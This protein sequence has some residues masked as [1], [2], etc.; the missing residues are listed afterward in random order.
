VNLEKIS[1]DSMRIFKIAGAAVLIVAVFVIAFAAWMGAFRSVTV[2]EKDAG[3]FVYAYEPFTGPYSKTQPAFDRVSAAVKAEGLSD[4]KGIGVYLDNPDLVPAEKLR[5]ECGILIQGLNAEKVTELSKRLKV[6]RIEA[7][8]FLYAEF[9]YR[10]ALSFMFGPVKV[11]PAFSQAVKEKG[12][13]PA[14]SIELYDSSSGK[15]GFLMPVVK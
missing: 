10:N 12:Y 1:E 15:I 4:D 7:G 8:R 2:T 5:S 14:Y 13:K 9:P 3:P 11:Y 6:K